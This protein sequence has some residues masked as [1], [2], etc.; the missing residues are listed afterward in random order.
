LKDKRE[1]G[2]KILLNQQ[3]VASTENIEGNNSIN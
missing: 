2:K 1:K 3:L